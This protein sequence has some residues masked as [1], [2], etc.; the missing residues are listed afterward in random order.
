LVA[1]V[2]G[3]RHP[4]KF[5]EFVVHARTPLPRYAWKRCTVLRCHSQ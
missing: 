4:G 1:S 5:A 3:F 2:V